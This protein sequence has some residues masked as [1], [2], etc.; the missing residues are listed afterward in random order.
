MK[1]ALAVTAAVVALG[2]ILLSGCRSGADQAGGGA[3]HSKPP[4]GTSATATDG[5][6]VADN[7]NP[8]GATTSKTGSGTVDTE[9]DSIDGLLGQ[10][11]DQANK[12]RQPLPDK[13]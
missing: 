11:D 6:G 4:T 7:T 10:Q 5:T 3:K 1:R 8:G 12:A 13:D 9:I 2:A